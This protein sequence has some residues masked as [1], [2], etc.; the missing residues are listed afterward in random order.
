MNY[1][2]EF[3]PKAAA[4]LRE[5][6][7][8]K[9]IPVGHVDERSITDVSPNDLR[10]FIQCHFFA[11]IGGWPLALRLARWPDKR[12]VGTGS[13]P[14][15]PFSGA[16]KGLAES[17]PR[18]L[19]PV[20]FNL[21][22][23]CHELGQSWTS[24][25][26]GEQVAS[27]L[28][29]QW[30]AGV[31]ADLETL[32]YA[33][34]AA[35]LCAAG[36]GAP[37]IRQRLYWV[38]DHG[39]RRCE[40]EIQQ[41]RD[42]VETVNE[43]RKA[44]FPRTGRSTRGLDDSRGLGRGAIGHDDRKHDWQLVDAAGDACGLADA[45][46]DARPSEQRDQSRQRSTPGQKDAPECGAAGGL[47]NAQGDDERRDTDRAHGEG[48]PVGGS[49]GN[50]AVGMGHAFQSRLEGHAGNGDGGNKSGRLDTLSAGSTAEAGGAG[51]W[52]A[53][54]IVHCLD[55]KA[56]RIEPGTF[57]LAHGVSGRV[58][59][60]RGYGNAIVPQVAAEFIKAASESIEETVTRLD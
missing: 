21:I 12:P 49:G 28:G 48:Q 41:S 17:D 18:H 56:R 23:D 51:Y 59:L 30:L 36:I 53:F 25:I 5:L 35:D 52:D 19:W 44:V 40:V 45:E 7:A 8:Q 57:P 31:R 10:G 24:T 1:Y 9:L 13:C 33:V 29:R 2:N 15:Q 27:K 58:G 39:R 43:R 54:E 47:G 26:F 46:H 14:C 37:H 32:A 50:G 11:G 3:D 6:I 4:W 16:G 38:A 20:L 60:L 34:G 42:C 55:G 22:R